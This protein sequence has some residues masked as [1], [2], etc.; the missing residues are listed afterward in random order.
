[1]PSK[2][3]E[4]HICRSSQSQLMF[5]LT[6]LKLCWS[7]ISN[8]LSHGMRSQC[9]SRQNCSS[10]TYNCDTRGDDARWSSQHRSEHQPIILTNHSSLKLIASSTSPDFN[11]FAAGITEIKPLLK[12]Q[13]YRHP[14]RITLVGFVLA[15]T[16][17]CNFY[18][19]HFN[20]M[21]CRHSLML[22]EYLILHY[23]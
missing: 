7:R 2:A 6:V 19:C 23:A 15:S 13:P 8:L 12:P 17:T 4:S 1:M 11:L 3:A 9:P 5:M 20:F 10:I 21:L 22:L 14:K 16:W 18:I